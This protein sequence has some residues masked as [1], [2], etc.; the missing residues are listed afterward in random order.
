MPHIAF[1]SSAIKTACAHPT[2][3]LGTTKHATRKI[4]TKARLAVKKN[5]LSTRK[6]TRVLGGL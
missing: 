1:T 3:V 2:N 4:T 5:A 6:R